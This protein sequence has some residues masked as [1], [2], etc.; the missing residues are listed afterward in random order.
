MG[1]GVCNPPTHTPRGMP[2]GA[3]IPIP[4]VGWG[5]NLSPCGGHGALPALG[6]GVPH[7]PLP[8]EAAPTGGVVWGGEEAAIYHHPPLPP[9]SH[10]LHVPRGRWD[11][12]FPPPPPRAV[13][14]AVAPGMPHPLTS[15][16]FHQ[17]APAEARWGGGD[18]SWDPGGDRT[19]GL[20]PG[21]AGWGGVGG[22]VPPLSP[23]RHCPHAG[24]GEPA[25]G[26]PRRDV[27]GRDPAQ[28]QEPSDGGESGGWD[29]GGG[30][31]EPLENPP[32]AP[33]PGGFTP[34][35]GFV[36]RSRGFLLLLLLPRGTLRAWDCGPPIP[37]VGCVCV[38]G[39]RWGELA[40]LSPCPI[41]QTIQIMTGFMHIGFG[42]VLTTLT[43]VY[44][45]V[46]VIGEIPFLGGVSVRSWGGGD[47]L[48]TCL[49]P[50]PIPWEG[51]PPR[52][53][54]SRQ[55]GAKGFWSRSCKTQGLT[56][57]R[58]GGRRAPGCFVNA[59]GVWGG[60]AR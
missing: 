16:A 20:A 15:P 26:Q 12:R 46:F 14:W 6:R 13:G 47:P 41:V 27:H 32:P 38:G 7:F 33:C 37:G 30:G 48:G 43:N 54:R 29:N 58:G 1:G 42:I 31:L 36:P 23:P 4:A 18:R 10:P 57:Q 60:G 35:P 11:P 52:S 39:V 34:L 8:T 3:P 25:A 21:P 44:T 28:G 49:P 17:S 24:D 9:I 50:P 59:G 22:V 5:L 45:S 56:T 53:Q 19:P 40:P 2:G 55:T 51:C